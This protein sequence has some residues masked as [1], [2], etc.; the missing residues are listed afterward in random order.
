MRDHVEPTRD[1]PS[2]ASTRD[3]CRV[4]QHTE[5][6]GAEVERGE[7]V[8]HRASRRCRVDMREHVVRRCRWVERHRIRIQRRRAGRTR[9]HAIVERRREPVRR[10]HRVAPCCV[11]AGRLLDPP[12][13]DRAGQRRSWR[14]MRSGRSSSPG[15]FRTVSAC[16]SSAGPASASSSTSVSAEKLAAVDRSRHQPSEMGAALGDE[17][18]VELLRAARDSGTSPPQRPPSTGPR[19]RPCWRAPHAGSSGDRRGDRQ[20]RRAV[21]RSRLVGRGLRRGSRL[22]PATAG[23]WWPCPHRPPP[24]FLRSTCPRTRPAP[25]RRGRRREWRDRPPPIEGGRRAGVAQAPR[26]SCFRRRREAVDRHQFDG[27]LF[28]P[29]HRC[30]LLVGLA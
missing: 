2:I 29:R 11:V 28:E 1:G 4:E 25:A 18:A 6:I 16:Q 17:D 23:R 26:R 22:C 19:L 14:T 15:S 8:L 10:A 30:G 13:V 3:P 9:P 7:A 21:P 20:C 24:R 27:L 5:A 12:A